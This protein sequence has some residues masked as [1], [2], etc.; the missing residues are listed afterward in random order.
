MEMDK[1]W[2]IHLTEA[3]SNLNCTLVMNN[4]EETDYEGG[5][6]KEINPGV[7]WL[8]SSMTNYGYI[9]LAPEEDMRPL[10]ILID[11]HAE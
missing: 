6:H 1:D 3:T 4:N 7:R 10:S 2:L 8:M 11:D 9:S 5:D